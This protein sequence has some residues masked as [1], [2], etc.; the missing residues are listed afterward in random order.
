MGT[1]L[2]LILGG[3]FVLGLVVVSFILYFVFRGPSGETAGATREVSGFTAV[4][5]SSYGD[6]T[7]IQGETE[8]LA[9][10][11][12]AD[13]LPHITA[14]VRNGK[15]IIGFEDNRFFRFPAWFMRS[16]PTIR[17]TLN[18]KE[19]ESVDLSG[20]GTVLAERL[21]AGDLEL[22]DSGAGKIT[23][24]QLTANDLNI[25]LSG[26]GA[27][28]VVGQVDSQTVNLSG[29]G[30]YRAGDLESR[31]ADVN[32]SGAGSATLWVHEQLDATL[33]GAG[34]IRYYGSPQANTTSSGVGEV[35]SLGDK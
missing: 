21:T 4:D 10:D 27:I 30:E 33:S 34:S 35:R 19:L 32:L 20:A 14:T 2:L 15:L 23:I 24:K 17:Y 31:Q 8:G 7:I 18:V 12:D 16:N 28:E 6:L 22:S 9:I 5:L 11:A 3:L 13:V 29:L 25:R 1:R 26:A